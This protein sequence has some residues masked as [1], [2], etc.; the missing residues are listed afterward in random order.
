MGK[1]ILFLITAR[2]G[3]KGLPG[4]NLRQLGGLSLIGFKARSALRSRHCLR[5]II[6][7]D[8]AD[9]RAEAEAHGAAAP[10]VR[11]AALATD[12]ASSDDVILHA[13]DYIEKEENRRYEAIMVLEPSS[14]FARGVDY[15]A[16]IELF[17]RADASCVVGIRE[18]RV[19]SIFVGPLDNDSKVEQII[20]K[21]TDAED[22]RRQ[23]LRREFTMNGALYLVSWDLMRTTGSI[24]GAPKTT[25]GYTMDQ[26][27]SQEIDT[28]YDFKLAEFFVR[29][30]LLDM[31]DWR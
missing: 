13:M 10:F 11:P 9:I 18:T 2:G 8:D 4:K 22:L 23:A 1:E 20:N 19:N 28:M 27:H 24:Y 26:A 7:T 15:D 31:A 29:E 30:G 21:L 17:E 3:S 5:L 12:V 25:Y 16:A 6:S 14:P